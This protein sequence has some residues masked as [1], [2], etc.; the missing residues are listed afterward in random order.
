MKQL[1]H[2]V[3][4]VTGGREGRAV[5]ADGQ[6]HVTMAFPTELGGTGQ[7]T[8]PEQLFAA[9]FAGCFASSLQFAAKG[10]GLDAGAVRVTS[11]VHLRVSDDGAYGITAQ[12]VTE[13]PGLAG[14]DRDRVM[15]EAER[16]CAYSNALRG[17]AAVTITAA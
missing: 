5:A 11:T 6:L 3:V 4:T 15:T 1:F 9:G 2:T 8:N 10:M 13:T 16:I 14:A 17:S 12:L 7:G